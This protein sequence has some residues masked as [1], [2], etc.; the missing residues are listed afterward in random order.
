MNIGFSNTFLD[1]PLFSSVE[2]MAAKGY[3]AGG[4]LSLRCTIN[5]VD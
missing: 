3:L 5:H 4:A 1:D 2:D